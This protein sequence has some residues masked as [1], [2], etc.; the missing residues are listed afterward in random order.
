MTNNTTP[1]TQPPTPP[2]QPEPQGNLRSILLSP[3]VFAAIITGGIGLIV[4]FIPILTAN[5]NVPEPTIPVAVVITAT[6]MPP[7]A[8]DAPTDAPE[9][10]VV[11]DEGAE[12]ST[13]E[14]AAEPTDVPATAT[15]IP[16]TAT[17]AQQANLTL[18]WDEVSFTLYNRS[19]AMLNISD[20]SFRSSNGN[21]MASQWGVA[22]SDSVPANNCLRM[23]DVSSNNRQPPALCGNL[24]GFQLVGGSALFWLNVPS[25]EVLDGGVVVATCETA[26]GECGIFVQ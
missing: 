11:T 10:V 7:T 24:L 5:N 15:P 2:G 13:S 8:T 9:E 6:P 14:T 12:D 21:W 4:A 16:P 17:P 3:Q 26:S 22:L 20:V 23:R 25:F 18:L 1:P 19:G